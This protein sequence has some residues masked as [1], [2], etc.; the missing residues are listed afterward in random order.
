LLGQRRFMFDGKEIEAKMQVHYMSF[1][2]HADAKG[3]TQL[4]RQ[5]QPS[6]V[7]L[8]HGEDLVMDF[9]QGRVKEELST[10]CFVR[11]CFFFLFFITNVRLEIPCFKP[12]NGE[13]IV[14][15]TPHGVPV[16]IE[17][18]L[19]QQLKGTISNRCNSSMIRT[20]CSQM[21]QLI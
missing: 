2:A 7:V 15:E 20:S 18:A 3:I 10:Y 14:I 19:V 13:T 11:F 8:V 6:N 21:K 1:S 16:D 9:L 4:I 17:P 12:A 5:C